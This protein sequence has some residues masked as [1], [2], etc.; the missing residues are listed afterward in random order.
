MK[1]C[2]ISQRQ[3]H[4]DPGAADDI[5]NWVMTHKLFTAACLGR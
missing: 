1:A 4:N 5:K 3:Q 2:R